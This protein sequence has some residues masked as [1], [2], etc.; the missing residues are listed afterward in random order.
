DLASPRFMMLDRRERTAAFDSL[1][2]PNTSILS[3]ATIYKIGGAVDATRLVQGR[4]EYSGGVFKAI[5]RVMDMEGPTL[6]AEFAESGQLQDLMEL[7]AGLAWQILRHM[8]PALPVSRDEFI[9]DHR[10]ARLDAFENYVRGLLS[11]NRADQ[12]RYFRNASRLDPN[13]TQPA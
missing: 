13:F 6:S 4:Y 8:R 11:K 10:I 1:G 7:E 12:I 2:I 5:A 9:S 3:T